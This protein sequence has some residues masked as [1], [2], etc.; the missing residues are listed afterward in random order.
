MSN[1]NIRRS[2]SL[3]SSSQSAKKQQTFYAFMKSDMQLINSLRKLH[4][5]SLILLP[6]KQIYDGPVSAGEVD[7]LFQYRI[8]DFNNDGKTAAIEYEEKCI[9]EGGH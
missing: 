8:D 6:A 1:S 7:F 4:K 5:G 3:A 2:N 9:K